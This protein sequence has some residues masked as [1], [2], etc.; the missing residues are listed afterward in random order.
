[1]IRYTIVQHDTSQYNKVHAQS[2]NPTP[3]TEALPATKLQLQRVNG[4][5]QLLPGGFVLVCMPVS[6]HAACQ[7]VPWMRGVLQLLGDRARQYQVAGV[8][9]G[10]AILRLVSWLAAQCVVCLQQH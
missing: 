8:G 7:L 5:P 10:T 9:A 2:S 6:C 3:A 4:G 1:M